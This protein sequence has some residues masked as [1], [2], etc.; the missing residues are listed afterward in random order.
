MD[1]PTSR[2]PK[3]QADINLA[4]LS[5]KKCGKVIRTQPL[6][7][8]VLIDERIVSREQLDQAL[9]LQQRKLGEILVDIGACKAEQLEQAMR[10]QR[11]GRTR[12]ELYASDLNKARGI[13][14]VL[15]LVTMLLGWSMLDAR[16]QAAFRARLDREELS[17]DEVMKIMSD[18]GS[19]YKFEALR[20]VSRQLSN[21]SGV[22]VIVAAMH[23]DKWYVRMYAAM[24]AKEAKSTAFVPGLVGLLDDPQRE[25]A[26]GAHQA[27]M[28]ITNQT[29]EPRS[30]V[31]I[32]WAKSAGMPVDSVKPPPTAGGTK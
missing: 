25:V 19:P 13:I 11:E 26:A 3:C 28:V 7:G 23:S 30:A 9:K 12:A 4:D 5:C 6:L 32:E 14:V 15:A 31:W 27:L 2:C 18:P 16:S 17:L 1:D 24:L 22:G 8:E 21:P 10:I 20:S 29:L